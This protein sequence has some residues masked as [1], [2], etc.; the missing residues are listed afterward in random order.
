M[1]PLVTRELDG[2]I[3][4]PQIENEPAKVHHAHEEDVGTVKDSI[5][6]FPSEVVAERY[7]GVAVCFVLKRPVHH[8]NVASVPGH[9]TE[10]SQNVRDYFDSL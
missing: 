10:Y 9:C 3:D 1:F 2:C 7:D 6:E 4:D 8:C 5:D